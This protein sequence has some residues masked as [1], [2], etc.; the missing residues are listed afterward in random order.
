[1]YFTERELRLLLD[2][3]APVALE[4]L[5]DQLGAAA[6]ERLRF[7][8]MLPSFDELW[9]EDPEGNRYAH[10]LVATV[11]ASAGVARPTPLGGRAEPSERTMSV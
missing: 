2:L 5:R 3:D 9:L 8:E 6:G 7:E 1:V 11:P 4:L 10:E